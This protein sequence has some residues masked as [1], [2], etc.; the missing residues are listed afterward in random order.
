MGS[1]AGETDW[2]GITESLLCLSE[3][4][5]FYPQCREK[6]RAASSSPLS[7]HQKV[8]RSSGPFKKLTGVGVGWLCGVTISNYLACGPSA[9]LGPLPG[10]PGMIH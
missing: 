3:D 1:K 2:G 6:P 9:T 8:I 10:W 7:P 4:L 5:K